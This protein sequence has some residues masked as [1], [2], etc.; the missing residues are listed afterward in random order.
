MSL[1]VCVFGFM[2]AVVCQS[3]NVV[4]TFIVYM[5]QFLYSYDILRCWTFQSTSVMV[6]VWY[7]LHF[8]FLSQSAVPYFFKFVEGNKVKR[9]SIMLDNYLSAA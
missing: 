2:A 7:L 5:L 9:N 8:S 6:F 4:T 1:N 3:Q